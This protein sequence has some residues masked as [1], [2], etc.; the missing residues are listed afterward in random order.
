MEEQETGPIGRF[1]DSVSAL[2]ATLLTIG[3][4]RLELLTV[5]LQL[6]VRRI[7]AII[8][9]A[10]IA[11]CASAMALMLAGL[12][13]I[14]VFWD[15]HR[16]LAAIGV[17]AAFLATALTAVLVLRARIREKPPLLQGTLAE[18]ARD[19]ERLGESRQ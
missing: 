15:S 12:A 8:L 13:V 6:E 17:S 5:E 7:A 10:V 19:A 18:L 16:V 11:A 14:V 1:M 3:R 9:W 4:T 2:L